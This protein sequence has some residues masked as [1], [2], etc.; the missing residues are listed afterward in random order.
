MGVPLCVICHFFLV[1]FS[2]LSW[3]FIFVNLITMGL[4]VFLPDCILPGTLHFLDLIDYFL[5]YIRE[6]FIYFPFKC[7]FG[8]SF[9]VSSPSGTPIM[10]MLIHLILSQRSL[11][12][13]SLKKKKNF[14]SIFSSVTMISTI[15]SS[16]SRIHSSA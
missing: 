10:W 2:I 15:L 1:A 9:S 13:S 3:S 5:S 11:R 4:G 6:V 14:F 16:R 12:R 8:G 7:F